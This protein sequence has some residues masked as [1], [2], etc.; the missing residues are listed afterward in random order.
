M[1][2]SVSSDSIQLFQHPFRELTKADCRSCFWISASPTWLL[3]SKWNPAPFSSPPLLALLPPSPALGRCLRCWLRSELCFTHHLKY[4][5]QE[6]REHLSVCLLLVSYSV[7]NLN[8]QVLP[9]YFRVSVAKFG[10]SLAQL[11]GNVSP[12]SSKYS[13]T[14]CLIGNRLWQRTSRVLY[15]TKWS[16]SRDYFS[17][18]VPRIPKNKSLFFSLFAAFQLCQQVG[19]NLRIYSFA[20]TKG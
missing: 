19:N 12:N 3:Y 16:D 14:A 11:S 17:R 5:F 15:Y 10:L 18:L 6:T 9:I 2:A 20:L 7:F 13:N 4:L 1:C 8:S